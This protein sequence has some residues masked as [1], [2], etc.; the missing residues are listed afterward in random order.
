MRELGV[1]VGLSTSS[2]VVVLKLHMERL[3]RALGEAGSGQYY[4][5]IVLCVHLVSLQ[6]A[7]FDFS[8]NEAV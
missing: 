3:K 4:V 6:C 8:P 7:V 2:S 5:C 1:A